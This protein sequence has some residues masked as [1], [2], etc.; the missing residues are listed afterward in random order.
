[1]WCN[2]S[3]Y[4]TTQYFD[5]TEGIQNFVTLALAILL[6]K[7]QKTALLHCTNLNFI[8]L[9]IHSWFLISNLKTLQ[10]FKKLFQKL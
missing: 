7:A 2:T 3:R 6:W 1:M 10:Y 8:F 5:T 4:V 9:V